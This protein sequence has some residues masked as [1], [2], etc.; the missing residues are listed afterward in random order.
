MVVKLP[1]VE[2]RGY[3]ERNTMNRI[4]H[5]EIPADDPQKVI[6]FY[7]QVFDLNV[8]IILPQENDSAGK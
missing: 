5:F 1:R 7:K 2:T 4:I 3:K 6:E 8:N